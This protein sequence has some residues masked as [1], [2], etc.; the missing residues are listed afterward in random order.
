M[1]REKVGVVKIA[2]QR[3]KRHNGSGDKRNENN[4][5][6]AAKAQRQQK[7]PAYLCSTIMIGSGLNG[8][9]RTHARRTR[10]T[11]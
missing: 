2:Y 5:G 6:M 10:T 4:N 8:A 9:T 3:L 7:S 1:A 11:L